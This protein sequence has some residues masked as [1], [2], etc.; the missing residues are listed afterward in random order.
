MEQIPIGIRS[1][2][3]LCA[4]RD[5]GHHHHHEDYHQHD[6]GDR[7]NHVH[8]VY[9][10]DHQQDGDDHHHYDQHHQHDQHDQGVHDQHEISSLSPLAPGAPHI[11]APEART[12]IIV[13][14]YFLL[15][16]I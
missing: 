2:G 14:F 3:I 6:Q 13:D 8:Y 10:D 15:Y 9:D 1:V 4:H 5:Q 12:S 7:D 16:F 11:S